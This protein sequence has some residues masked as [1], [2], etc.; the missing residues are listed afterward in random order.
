MQLFSNLFSTF[1]DSGSLDT[2][3]EALEGLANLSIASPGNDYSVKLKIGNYPVVTGKV[4]P[5]VI[6][7][8]TGWEAFKWDLGKVVPYIPYVNVLNDAKIALTGS[9]FAGYYASPGEQQ[10]AKF[11]TV[12]NVATVGTG[13]LL[14]AELR[15]LRG[16]TEEIGVVAKGLSKTEKLSK[17]SPIEIPTSATIKEQ[18]KTGY[19]QIQY[20]WSDGTYKY[21]ARWHTRTPSA[22][23]E[24]G[25]TWVVERKL[26]GEGARQPQTE[27]LTGEN[28]WTPQWKWQEAILARKDGTATAEQ[29]ALLSGGHWLAP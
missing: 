4:E 20:K 28:Q 9:D 19:D 2:A 17:S 11:Q 27:I 26:P 21:E 29:D 16:T 23:E 24:Q 8:M 25:N 10:D 1:N 18:A 13:G 6:R 15:S 7:P 5:D 14:G 3:L 12:L 22:P